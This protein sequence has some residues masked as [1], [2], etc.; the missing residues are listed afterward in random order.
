MQEEP[1]ALP[2][3][4]CV[5]LGKSRALSGLRLPALSQRP[6]SSRIRFIPILEFRERRLPVSNSTSTYSI[7]GIYLFQ[8]YWFWAGCQE[9]GKCQRECPLCPS[10][11]SDCHPNPVSFGGW[12]SWAA[13]PARLGGWFLWPVLPATLPHTI[14]RRPWISHSQH[15]PPP[16]LSWSC[17][18]F[19]NRKKDPHQF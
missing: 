2:R 5:T 19:S 18:V 16:Q 13:T 15:S 7:R 6:S 17:W 14:L 8:E 12:V 4:S 11:Q 1:C 3:Q 10:L 9:I